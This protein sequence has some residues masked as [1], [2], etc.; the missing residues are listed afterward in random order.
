MS[1]DLTDAGFLRGWVH[2]DELRPG[3]ELPRWLTKTART[4]F[5]RSLMLQDWY[6]FWGYQDALTGGEFRDGYDGWQEPH[7][8]VYQCGR[9]IVAF[10]RSEGFEPPAWPRKEEFAPVL[11]WLD[12]RRRRFPDELLLP[13]TTG[14]NH[15]PVA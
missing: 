1:L 9:A 3:D 11:A 5:Q 13:V 4:S 14:G 10:M 2:E 15:A 8:Q 12:D 7:Q 6:C